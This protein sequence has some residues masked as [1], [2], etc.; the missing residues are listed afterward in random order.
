MNCFMQCPSRKNGH[1][2]KM[3]MRGFAAAPVVPATARRPALQTMRL[4]SSE[5]E[6][7]SGDSMGSDQAGGQRAGTDMICDCVA[8]LCY[9]IGLY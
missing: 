3:T 2:R 8:A 6:A 1:G 9:M 4:R 7:Q 5:V